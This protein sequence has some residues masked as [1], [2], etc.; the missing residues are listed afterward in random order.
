[1]IILSGRSTT[2]V[3]AYLMKTRRI[4]RK[5]AIELIQKERTYVRLESFIYC[6]PLLVQIS[7]TL[8]SI[9]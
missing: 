4:T 7:L 9:T 1:M 3:A 6:R 5:E 2:V 8:M